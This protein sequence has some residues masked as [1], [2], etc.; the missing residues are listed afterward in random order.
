[1]DKK[2]RPTNERPK[3]QEVVLKNG[4]FSI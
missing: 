1:M 4:F 2:P 3:Q